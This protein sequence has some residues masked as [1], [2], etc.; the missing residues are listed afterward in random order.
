MER[1]RPPDREGYLDYRTRLENG[2][3]EIGARAAAEW[4][5][6]R[7]RSS[8]PGQYFN[9]HFIEQAIERHQHE[10]PDLL[11]QQ[12]AQQ[13]A[14]LREATRREARAAMDKAAQSWSTERFRLHID[15]LEVCEDG[16]E[17]E[18]ASRRTGHPD[19][20]EAE[21]WFQAKLSIDEPYLSHL[22]RRSADLERKLQA[23]AEQ[24]LEKDRTPE[25]DEA[26]YAE[27][28]EELRE[29]GREMKRDRER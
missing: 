14:G 4:H 27:F 23:I 25:V 18:I 1:E 3:L 12:F 29:L 22:F 19:E 21:A 24:A 6:K 10:N 20:T 11:V 5:D 2:D 17:E 9:L 26:R 8:A 15:Y 28:R 16:F 7:E 13:L